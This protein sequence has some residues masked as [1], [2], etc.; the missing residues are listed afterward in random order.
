MNL[1]RALAL[2]SLAAAIS[3]VAGCG[4]PLDSS[5]R[6]IPVGQIPLALRETLPTAP[7]ISP[8]FHGS[9]PTE[10]YLLGPDSRLVAV[11]RYVSAPPTPQKI[12]YT[13]AAGPSVAESNLGIQ[14]AIQ[15]AASLRAGPLTAGTLTVLLDSTFGTLRPGE[16]TYEFAQIVYSVTSLAN[17]RGVLFKYEGGDIDPEIGNG[18]IASDYVVNRSD[19]RQLLE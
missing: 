16:E 19:Y 15:P 14:S 2:G 10:I 1:K 13:L 12:L 18:S 3:A 4:L 6:A 17:V 8:R 5:P 7:P 9:T 11:S